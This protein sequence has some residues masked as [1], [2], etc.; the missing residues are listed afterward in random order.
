[1]VDRLQQL[2][3]VFAIDVAAY[4]VMSNHYHLVLHIDRF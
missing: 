1:V 4:V 3:G 2:C